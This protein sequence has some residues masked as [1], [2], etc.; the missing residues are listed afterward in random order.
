MKMIAMDQ[1]VAQRMSAA[2]V[3]S[4]PKITQFFS[5]NWNIILFEGTEGFSFD[6]MI[7]PGQGLASNTLRLLMV[8]N[9]MINLNGKSMISHRGGDFI[10]LCALQ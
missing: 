8:K 10:L 4:G 6:L 7:I 1:P 5:F 2:H 3:R 9:I